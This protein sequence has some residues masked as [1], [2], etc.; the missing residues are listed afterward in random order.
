MTTD[1]TEFLFKLLKAQPILQEL[2]FRNQ[3][4]KR[5]ATNLKQKLYRREKDFIKKIQ[6][7]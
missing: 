6:N 7:T 5:K 3:L 1:K 4:E 2:Y